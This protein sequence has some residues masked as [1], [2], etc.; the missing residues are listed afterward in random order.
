[1][2]AGSGS[3]YSVDTAVSAAAGRLLLGLGASPEPVALAALEEPA[4]SC[5]IPRQ[6]DWP[7]DSRVGGM[8]VLS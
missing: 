5:I 6:I 8:P 4:T 1:M 7:S 2:Y 3:E